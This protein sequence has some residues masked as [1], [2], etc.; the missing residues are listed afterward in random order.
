MAKNV[1]VVLLEDIAEIGRAG[2]IVTVSEGYARN[3]LF[4]EGKAALATV[5][6]KKQQAER[7]ARDKARAAAEL[8]EFQQL[9]EVLDDTEL[10]IGAQVKDGDEIYGTITAAVIAKELQQQASIK[11]KPRDIEIKKPITRLG[12][13]PVTV[14]LSPDVSAT[15]TVTVT[16][17]DDE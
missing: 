2:D 1:Q 12:S 17:D 6:T 16:T 15:I 8:K 14:N 11:V 4:N 5:E 9:A 10:T 7:R 13:Q 3:F